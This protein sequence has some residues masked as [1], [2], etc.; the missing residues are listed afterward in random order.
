MKRII[1][2]GSPGSGKTTLSRSLAEKTGLP[3]VHLDKLFW[4]DGWI[5]VSKEE[6]DVLLQ[7]KLEK[8]EWIIDGNF[9]RTIPLRLQYCDTVIWLDF[10]RITCISGVI[11]RVI[12]NYGK[13]RPDMGGNCP[14][15]FDF[16][17][18]RT[19]WGF[20]KQHRQR[21]N[22]MLNNTN[23]IRVIKLKNR[24]EAAQFLENI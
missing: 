15:R 9:N 11:K 19:V 2:I 16:E 13:T 10:P 14:E 8:P 20:N 17:F 22:E 23:G 12:A 5:S 4:R 24:K 7:T 6:F 18:L 3:L 1:I 21:Y